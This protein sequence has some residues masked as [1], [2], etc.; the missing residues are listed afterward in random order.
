MDN[1]HPDGP[2]RHPVTEALHAAHA[3]LDAITVAGDGGT[4]GWVP[5][6]GMDPVE[7]AEVV[8][9]HAALEGRVAGLRLH[10]VA[11]AD[12]ANAAE[13][14]AAADTGSWA[15]TAGRNRSRAW[16][17]VW[18][19]NLLN[20]T[21]APT[22]TALAQGRISEEHAAV[23]VRA[24]QK[25]PESVTAAQLAEC[26][27]ILVEKAT[28]MSPENLRRAARRLLAPLSKELADAH[29]DQLLVEQEFHAECETWLT[30]CDNGDGTWGGKFVIPELHGWLFKTRL[31]QL[32][33]PRRHTRT[34]TGEPVED[35]TVGNG[36]N[37]TEALGAAFLEILEH[38]PEH[39]HA[40]SGVSIVVHVE[41]EKLRT[42]LGAA[43]VGTGAENGPKIS[44]QEVRRLLCEAS[45]L[46]LIMGGRSLPL[47][48]GRSS[49]LFTKNQ[50]I[51]LSAIHETCTAQGCT[52][53][54]AW[55]EL[56]HK[57][58]WSEG[59]P[60]DLDNAAPLCGHH[61]RRIHD[62]T[63][64]HQW[65]PDGTVRFRHRWRSRW[66]HRTDP[67]AQPAA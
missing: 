42:Q 49:R 1:R 12:A 5:M 7:L 37:Y 59:G 55:T 45:I 61:H 56:H 2:D 57:K 23:I 67:W 44:N 54:F 34:K 17:G 53:P 21:Y 25:V 29:E 40:R 64:E 11:A 48:L 28:R 14:T 32:T 36:K 26:E 24:A 31:E 66:K 22:R 43:T 38:L 30:L 13:V 63:Y 3:A 27:A 65:L 4:A 60:T 47:D 18:L 19:A 6:A 58:P 9:L 52:R 35:R 10:T 62:D 39:G 41:E 16:G 20:S 33:S 46:P 15:A 51:A 8:R 50:W